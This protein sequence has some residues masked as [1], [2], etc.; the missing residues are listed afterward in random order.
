MVQAVSS[1]LAFFLSVCAGT[2]CHWSA[3]IHDQGVADQM[4][5]EAKFHWYN[6]RVEVWAVE[7]RQVEWQPMPATDR[8]Y[9]II[10]RLEKL[11]GCER[12][13]VQGDTQ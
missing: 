1:F 4:R 12:E 6:G 13:L 9:R 5:Q 7:C 10:P 2:V 8:F 11:V 3:P